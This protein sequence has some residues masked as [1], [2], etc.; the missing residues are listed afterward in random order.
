M[1]NMKF[2]ESYA[3]RFEEVTVTLEDQWVKIQA[4]HPLAPDI[5]EGDVFIPNHNIVAIG[6]D[7]K[8]ET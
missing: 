5:K 7:T 6:M 1:H 3:N 4:R 2:S 8:A